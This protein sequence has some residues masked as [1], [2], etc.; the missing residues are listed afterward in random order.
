M[1]PARS[2]ATSRAA[3]SPGASAYPSATD[4][5]TERDASRYVW[6]RLRYH[7]AVWHTFVLAGSICHFLSVLL[8]LLPRNT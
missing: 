2:A 7:H 6:H 5:M 1:S 8:Y 4:G 3:R